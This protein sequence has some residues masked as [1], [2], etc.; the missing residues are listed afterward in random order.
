MRKKNRK[1]LKRGMCFL[2]AGAMI[3]SGAP[4]GALNDIGT[5][6]V[7]AEENTDSE[8]A[9]GYDVTGPVIESAN[10]VENGQTISEGGTFTVTFS[11]YDAEGSI[12]L[13]EGYCH[14]IGETE[15][16]GLKS[17]SIVYDE[18]ENLY[19]MSFYVDYEMPYEWYALD[20][21]RVL[22]DSG[23]YSIYQMGDMEQGFYAEAAPYYAEIM[24]IKNITMSQ[25]EV[26]LTEDEDTKYVDVVMD[27]EYDKVFDE[28]YVYELWLYFA[29]D[30][31][32]ENYNI[33]TFSEMS[34]YT[35][36]D[37]EKKQFVGT[38][39]IDK[40]YSG[41]KCYLQEASGSISYENEL[42]FLVASIDEI[43]E[44]C[45][46]VKRAFPS[47]YSCIIDDMYFTLNGEQVESGFSTQTGDEVHFVIE[48]HDESIMDENN[49]IYIDDF[50]GNYKI[51]TNPDVSDGKYEF[52]IP[53]GELSATDCYVT[54]L[55]FIDI[56]GNAP[57]M[58]ENYTGKYEFSRQG[59]YSRE[60]T[61]IEMNN[62]YFYMY[63][64]DECNDKSID[65]DTTFTSISYDEYMGYLQSNMYEPVMTTKETS[66]S[67]MFPQGIPMPEE[68]EG[69]EFI[70]WSL[71]G[72][73]VNEDTTIILD[74]PYSNGGDELN[75][76]AVYDKVPVTIE[77]QYCSASTA[78]DTQ[79]IGLLVDKGSTYADIMKEVEEGNIFSG[80]HSQ[81]VVFDCWEIQN[82]VN[83]EE[84][85]SNNYVCIEL[86]AKYNIV[87]VDI[88]LTYIDDNNKYVD[89]SKRMLLEQNT[90]YAELIKKINELGITHTTDINFVEWQ[91]NYVYYHGVLKEEVS[92]EEE[93][94]GNVY[95]GLNAV[96]DKDCVVALR[97]YAGAD[98]RH[99]YQWDLYIVED[100]ITYAE[101]LVSSNI[102]AEHANEVVFLGWNV[103]SGIDKLDGTICGQKRIELEARYD[104]DF[105]SFAIVYI[106][107]YDCTSY[108]RYCFLYD[109][110]T[111]YKDIVNIASQLDINHTKNQRLTDWNIYVDGPSLDE[112]P[113]DEIY[114]PNVVN[115]IVVV[116]RYEDI[117]A[118]NTGEYPYTYFYMDDGTIC[119]QEYLGTDE[120]EITIPSEIEGVP[121]TR[122]NDWAFSGHN[123]LTTVNIPDSVTAI[124]IA[125]FQDCSSL[126]EVNIS[127]Y[128]TAI[129]LQAFDGCSSLR[130]IN[131]SENN[132]NYKSIDGVLFD[133][134]G[135]ELIKYPAGCE[136]EE[137]SIPEGTT[138]VGNGAFEGCSNLET[139][140]VPSSLSSIDDWAIADCYNLK[141][142][143]VSENNLSYKSTDGIMFS[144]TGEGLI[145]YPAGRAEE[146]YIVPEGVKYISNRAFAQ[147]SL[148]EIELCEGIIYINMQAFSGC[149]CLV[150]ISIPEGVEIIGDGAFEGC[151]SLETIEIPDTVTEI[152]NITFS[153]C[154]SLTTV[155]IPE[156]VTYIGDYI[157]QS[158]SSLK[159]IYIPDS[160]QIIGA[161]AFAYCSSLTSVNIPDGV[162]EIYYGTFAGCDNLNAIKIP[163]SVEGI[164]DDALGY[165]Y[166]EELNGYVRNDNMVIYGYEGTE[167]QAYAISE[168]FTFISIK[169]E[170]DVETDVVVEYAENVIDKIISVVVDKLEELEDAYKNLNLEDKFEK[171]TSSG[172]KAEFKVY[173]IKLL[174]EE[175]NEIQ[176]TGNV[177]VKLPCPDNYNA[178]KCQVYHVDDEGKVTNMNA[179]FSNGYFMFATNHFSVYLITESELAGETECMNGDANGDE[180]I[181]TQ[182]AVLLKKYLAGYTDLD[183]KEEAC[184]V[185][186]DGSINSETMKKSL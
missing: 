139:I 18:S 45:V 93:I 25:S 102:K 183:I 24:Q 153:G 38:M 50:F 81:E 143:N 53:L 90:T 12:S 175:G 92:L 135:R 37:F 89:Y 144:K 182:D 35:Q 125:A 184:D 112:D 134:T 145:K 126:T 41:G 69:L 162:K 103:V 181:D 71:N 62:C 120:S 180:K 122:I 17:S 106:D 147:S 48:V 15:D 174:D 32:S 23:N 178:E 60:T 142:I 8:P 150:S 137:Y 65:V 47:E 100:D 94:T 49:Y 20:Y 105:G 96:Y 86:N 158:C 80:E 110:Y 127:E 3:L 173:D 171:I 156:G 34:C 148:S 7:Y 51:L 74:Y 73:L 109:E 28:S 117:N 64:A 19:T 39:E 52:D 9:T 31:E 163:K 164:Y 132:L 116:A 165:I 77:I 179:K 78:T 172:N 149:A 63:V 107:D 128:V 79:W 33:S 113:L 44:T 11:G 99:K 98:N 161:G 121:V 154:S 36:Y 151:C 119:I 10:L 136:K 157:F 141:S 91:Y 146:K 84:I 118:G 85:V 21:I 61:T 97:Q 14:L 58:S 1:M 43:P 131:V 167:A 177:T 30:E 108:D 29:V 75:F 160:V 27:V 4:V 57:K 104:K 13:E 185:N 5:T 22:D 56:Y 170:A 2:L 66:L 54:T 67:K 95:M 76:V 55:Q 115:D 159:E 152:G 87:P 124:E 155:N 166:S 72:E 82:E 16:L 138:S 169:A 42:G 111:T 88:S 40:T 59:S 133:K 46:A 130:N 176:P 68:V 168:G 101:F 6:K 83:I 114:D 70:G 26:V 129:D 186:K 123:E 140:N